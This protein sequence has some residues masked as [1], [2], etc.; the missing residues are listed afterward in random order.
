MITCIMKHHEA[1]YTEY[2][3]V[4]QNV[5]YIPIRQTYCSPNIPRIQYHKVFI[6]V[7][8]VSY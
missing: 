5:H 1:M 6:Y 4:R 2:C 7:H 3:P 8:N